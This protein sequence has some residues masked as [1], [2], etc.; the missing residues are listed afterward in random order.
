MNLHLKKPDENAISILFLCSDLHKIEDIISC[1][2]F[3]I[4]M[5]LKSAFVIA[6]K[7]CYLLVLPNISCMILQ[8][9][10]LVL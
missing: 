5:C 3:C 10:K 6:R 2:R 9:V 4:K 8:V 7:C 1:K